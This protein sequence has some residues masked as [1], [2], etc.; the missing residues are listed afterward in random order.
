MR[1]KPLIANRNADVLREA[2]NVPI[3]IMYWNANRNSVEMTLFEDVSEGD[4]AALLDLIGIVFNQ[5]EGNK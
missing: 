3:C 5:V 1:D 2:A 4:A